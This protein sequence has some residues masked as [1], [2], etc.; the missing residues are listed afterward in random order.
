MR[1]SMCVC[2]KRIQSGPLLVRLSL[3]YIMLQRQLFMAS[4]FPQ[5]SDE[6]VKVLTLVKR[7][8]CARGINHT[9]E[10]G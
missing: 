6:E 3:I 8:V 7:E 5:P 1:S 9:S 10:R 2:L 4:V